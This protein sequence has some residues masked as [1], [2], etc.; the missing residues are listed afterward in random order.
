MTTTDDRTAVLYC[1]VSADTTGRARSV[2]EQENDC[3]RLCED[4]GWP[5]RAVVVDNDIS[6]S[7]W[8][9]KAR[10][11][12]RDLLVTLRAGDILVC[13]EPS[14][15]TRQPRELE[16]IIDLCR[17]RGVLVAYASG[18]IYDPAKSRD[19]RAMRSDAVDSAY[20][21]DKARD[22]VM[23]AHA[24]NLAAGKPHGRLPWGYRAV[25]DERSGRIIARVPKEP[26]AQIIR[27]AA[28]A[29][30]A[31]KGLRAI[32]ADFNARGVPTPA[33]CDTW[34]GKQLRQVLLRSSNAGLRS[35]QGVVTGEG[36]WDGILS[37]QDWEQVCAILKDPK[38]T[39]TRGP[40]PRYL[41]SGI[42]I[43]DVC[44]EPVYRLRHRT[45]ENCKGTYSCV[46]GAR[47]F[48]R[49]IEP[50]DE[51]VEQAV[52]L[53]LAG[54]ELMTRLKNSDDTADAAYETASAL[55]AELDAQIDAVVSQGLPPAIT[56]RALGKLDERY[57]PRIEAAEKRI[58]PN[59]LL[60]SI[61]GPDAPK[62]WPG[63]SLTMRRELIRSALNIRI[64]PVGRGRRNYEIA[65][66]VKL[67]WK[68]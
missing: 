44:E 54:P 42:A 23:R 7:E 63:L 38:R 15:I 43:C 14:R 30:L 34:A 37:V 65:D 50:I 2:T 49:K 35:H 68:L 48:Q 24:A 60:A 3:R 47:H 12:Y 16:D 51:Y 36:T 58:R 67:E 27:D 64:L 39:T 59:S 20:E 29:V 22:R 17:A 53:M 26:E 40:E 25:R 62:R 19:R 9:G 33:G 32:V 1:R 28:A 18:D 56:A 57:T 21:A 10:P 5:V 55:R 31:G 41:L 52:V 11:G 46:A 13:W 8:G 61:A 6:A 45:D 4:E 66:T